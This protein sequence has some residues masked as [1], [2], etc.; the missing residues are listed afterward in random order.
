MSLKMKKLLEIDSL[1][2]AFGAT[3][4]LKSISFDIVSGEVHAL[5]GEN[6]AGKSTCVKILNG[7]LQPD[8][9][10]I[11]LNGQ[12]YRPLGLADARKVGISTAFQELS[13]IPDLSVAVNL[14]MPN[15]PRNSLRFVKFGEVRR[16]A[17]EVL[18]RYGM[19]IRPSS[20]VSSLALADKQRLEIIRAL[21]RN[22]KVL[23]LDEPT[24]ALTDVRWLYQQIADLT[25]QG[26]A[27]IFITHRLKE[28]RD[29]CQRATVLR[30]G[31]V[32]GN[33]HLSEV[34]DGELFRLM[35]GRSMGTTFPERQRQAKAV[36]P[37]ALAVENFRV[38][39]FGPVNFNVE[40]G[41]VVGVAALEGQ[42]QRELFRGLAGLERISGAVRI[43]DR[44][45][46][47]RSAVTA[48]QL[49]ISFVP[50]ERK[51]DGLFFGISTR[52]NVSISNV[53]RVA[54]WGIVWRHVEMGAISDVCAAIDLDSRFYDMPIDALSGGNQQKALIARALFA[55]S[56][57]LL[58]FDPT[59]GVDVGTKQ[60]IYKVIRKCA[61]HGIGILLYST[62][63]MEI[64]GLCD[65]CI[66]VYGNRVVGQCEGNQLTEEALIERMHGAEPSQNEQEYS[67]AQQRRANS[68]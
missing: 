18:A 34:S 8:A 26:G 9:G 62:E 68:L 49:G 44:P 38:G 56:K 61:E 20:M 53:R 60:S 45:V 12:E 65:R 55:N 42:G 47:I 5:L 35:I 46:K 57:C 39:R 17:E 67:S 31:Q 23:I 51:E 21:S 43:N 7:L 63:L 10:A 24:A 54:K 32:A 25:A 59:R 33:V 48:K 52:G 27:V 14:V 15:L 3:Q 64:V 6:G 1:D 4:A 58:M 16:R 36:A 41:E 37:A 2:K 30:N 22:P 50:E 11:K 29:L 13:L 40:A 66:V 28:I 19:D